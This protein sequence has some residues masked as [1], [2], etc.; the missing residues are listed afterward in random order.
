MPGL[1]FSAFK[2]P[3][4]A[5]EL[6]FAFRVKP[7][8]PQVIEKKAQALRTR[9][10][11]FRYFIETGHVFIFPVLQK[12][13]EPEPSV[14]TIDQK[15]L[16]RIFAGDQ[17]VPPLEVTVRKTMPVQGARSLCNLLRDRCNPLSVVQTDI[18]FLCHLCQIFCIGNA[19]GND[20]SALENQSGFFHSVSDQRGARNS[21]LLK[22]LKVLPLAAQ[23]RTADPAPEPF[24]RLPVEFYTKLT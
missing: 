11:L 22:T 14:R 5:P 9:Q 24:A 3:D 18:F 4:D 21:P 10:N 19:F 23:S 6:F 20:G 17:D 15:D 13:R 16:R 7:F 8:L 1:L 12:R 2:K